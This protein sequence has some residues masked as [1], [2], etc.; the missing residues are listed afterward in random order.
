MK[1]NTNLITAIRKK[2]YRQR[3]FA[4]AVKEHETFISRVING[5]VNLDEKR[6]RKFARVLET[7][8]DELFK[9]QD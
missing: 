8:V 4:K 9:E 6:K 1:P 2:G 3:D 7:S 5:W